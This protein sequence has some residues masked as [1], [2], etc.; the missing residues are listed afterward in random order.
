MP[1]A[2]SFS[3]TV[4]PTEKATTTTSSAKKVTTSTPPPSDD[5]YYEDEEYDYDIPRTGVKSKHQHNADYD[6]PTGFE[7]TH[8]Y[9]PRPHRARQP[10]R[11]RTDVYD[12][13]DVKERPR[14]NRRKEYTRHD[15]RPRNRPAH[16]NKNRQDDEGGYSFKKRPVESEHPRRRPEKRPTYDDDYY[17]DDEEEV[18]P[19][20]N[21]RPSKT[22]EKPLK[23]S[24]T[25][26]PKMER[27]STESRPTT[28]TTTR[29]TKVTIAYSSTPQRNAKASSLENE[30]TKEN[31]IPTTEHISAR[32]TQKYSYK[33]IKIPI[34]NNVVREDAVDES[35]D[36]PV[37]TEEARSSSTH[38]RPVTAIV[39][40]TLPAKIEPT[41]KKPADETPNKTI[42]TI[43]H[44]VIAP[45]VR[46]TSHFGFM[47]AAP[48]A[49]N[50]SSSR[51]EAVASKLP[52]QKVQQQQHDLY[53]R[54][55]TQYIK[56]PVSMSSI[57]PQHNHSYQ[58]AS[59]AFGGYYIPIE[60]PHK[61]KQAKPVEENLGENL[62]AISNGIHYNNAF[63][64]TKSQTYRAHP[65]Q[66]QR[67]YT[68]AISFPQRPPSN[69]DITA[70][71]PSAPADETNSAEN[72][73]YSEL[74]AYTA[75]ADYDVTYNDALQPSTLHPVRRFPSTSFYIQT[76]QNQPP[77]RQTSE[78]AFNDSAFHTLNRSQNR[79]SK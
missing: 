8:R 18:P 43:R 40:K 50:A 38:S 67:L 49:V 24:T 27:T 2:S 52:E 75:N 30:T 47:N 12:D 21:H 62:N 51:D 32:T 41:S 31:E 71:G 54:P 35:A 7:D 34:V 58:A 66:D 20:R 25:K 57:A 56:I 48:V 61:S 64:S 33:T 74:P 9:V 14:M 45:P 15:D 78:Y 22:T 5:E 69:Y 44:F 46:K 42:T 10:A 53:S 68:N 39:L 59:T 60:Q 70:P 65:A 29:Q 13:Y 23:L 55:Q 17:Y 1:K 37:S 63:E 19:K 11:K 26:Q 72:K 6:F 28:E 77:R 76:H 4:A 79:Y 3:S 16:R 36:Y 73:R